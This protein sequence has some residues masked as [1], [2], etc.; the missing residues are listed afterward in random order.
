MRFKSNN[1]KKVGILL[2][3]VVFLIGVVF[4]ST[5]L[6]DTEAEFDSGNYNLTEF[7]STGGYI[8]LTG[9]DTFQQ[10]PNDAIDEN[11]YG[12]VNMTGN[13]GLWHM[14]EASGTVVDYSGAGN[15]GSP[16]GGPNYGVAGKLNNAISFEGSNEGIN[17]SND[18]SLNPS[19]MTL[20][21]WVNLDG[22]DSSYGTILSRW[23]N[24]NAYYIGTLPSS[25]AVVIYYSGSLRYTTP[26][27][28]TG[29]WVHFLVTNDGAG[30]T[31][32]YYQ[33]GAYVGGGASGGAIS[34][35]TSP[36]SIGYDVE[37]SN[38]PFK[39]NIDEFAIWNRSLSAQEVHDIYQRQKNEYVEVGEYTSQ[40]FNPGS[41]SQW[42]NLS[43]ID[44]RVGVLPA[45]Q[46]VE[47][48]ANM[49]FNTVLYYLNE[50][51]GNITDYSGNGYSAW[52]YDFEGDEYNATGQVGNGL[53]FDGIDDIL[54]GPGSNVVI[55]EN[56][57]YVSQ[58]VWFKTTS[59]AAMYPMSLK[60]SAAN[61]TLFSITIGNG[62]AGNAGLLTYNA[63]GGHTYLNHNGGY[64]DGNWHLLVGVVDGLDRIVYVDGVSVAS[65]TDGITSVTGNIAQFTV[66]G[67]AGNH[68]SLFFGGT[69]DD[70]AVFNRSLT[71]QEVLDIYNRGLMK[72]NVSV[73]SCDDAA[74]DGEGWTDINDTSP[75]QLSLGNNS[76]FQYQ[77]EFNGTE[78]ATPSLANVTIEYDLIPTLDHYYIETYENNQA[79]SFFA[80]TTEVELRTNTTGTATPTITITDSEGIIWV[81]AENMINVSNIY[82]YNYTLNGSQGWYDVKINSQD[83]YKTF[84]QSQT[85]QGNY[86]DEDGNPFSFRRKI[87][88]TEPGTRERFFEPI[89]TQI[90]F[91]YE[92][93]NNSVRV[94][95]YNG[96][97]YLEIPSQIYNTNQTGT[98]LYSS[99]VVFLSSLNQSETR[100]YYIVSSKTANNK[101]YTSDIIYSNTSDFY[102]ISNSYFTS[103][104]NTSTGGLMQNAYNA[105]GTN[106]S[107]YGAHPMD[108]YPEYQIG[109]TT[110]SSRADTSITIGN[111]EG[112]LLYFFNVS[113][114]SSDDSSKPYT[115]N[116]KI[117]SK[118]YQIICEK[119]QTSTATQDWKN[120]YMN[121]VIVE[122]ELFSLSAYENSSNVITNQSLATVSNLDQNMKWVAFY[123]NSL[124]NAI[125]EIFLN[126][127]FA[128]TNNPSFEIADD[129]GYDYYQQ[130]VID[131]TAQT[132]NSG[133]YFY[134]K[135]AK[136]IYNGMREYEFVDQ[137][138]D[139]LQNPVTID[140]ASEETSDSNNPYYI[141][142][143]TIATSDQANL[144]F[145]SYWA[146]DSF[147]DYAIINITG[148]G[149][150]GTSTVLYQNL[151]S[152]IRNG[153]SIVNES[154]VNITLNSSE[155]NAGNVTCNITAYDISGKYN[156][157]V[158]I[159]EVLDLTPPSIDLVLNNPNVTDDLDPNKTIEINVTLFEYSTLDKVNLYYRNNNSG[160]WS[161]WSNT[162][163]ANIVSST[164]NYTYA[165]NI[166]PSLEA[167]Y[168]YYIGA[169]DTDSNTANSS[170]YNLSAYF[171]YSWT[172][173]DN[174]TAN[175]GV[176]DTNISLGNLTL[177]NTGDYNLTFTGSAGVFGSRI[178]IN[179]SQASTSPQFEVENG[180]SVELNV[181][182]TTRES[183]QTEGTDAVTITFSNNTAT[184][185]S[186][187]ASVSLVTIS[188]GPFLHTEITQYNQTVN[189][190]DTGISLTARVTN[191]GNETATN[192]NVTFV[193]PTGWS[194][195][196]EQSLTSNFGTLSV[197]S[198]DAHQTEVDISSSA[199]AGAQTVTANSIC[200]ENKT[201]STY[202][203]ITVVDPNAGGTE[204]SE[205]T[206][207][208][209]GGGGGGGGGASLSVEE[210]NRF[211]SSEDSFELVRG[212]DQIFTIP[213]E[214]PYDDAIL[215][216]LRISLQGFSKDY[217]FFYPGSIS[218]LGIG[219]SEDIKVEITAPGYFTQG[220]YDLE[221][222]FEGKLYNTNTSKTIDFLYT[223]DVALY[224]FDV[225]RADATDYKLQA[226]TY[227]QD[228]MDRGYITDDMEE[229]FQQLDG[230]YNITEFGIVKDIFEQIEELYEAAVDSDE[231][232][233]ELEQALSEAGAKKINVEE[234]E[235]LVHLA[236]SSFERGD[237]L[238]ALERVKEAK[239]TLAIESSGKFFKEVTYAM[240]ENPGQT[241]AGFG[242]F[243]V[244]VV[245][246]SLFTRWRYIKRKLK[247]LGEE[248]NLLTELMKA[249]QIEV[250]EKAK[251]SMKEYGESM[252]QYEERLGNIIG[253]KITFQNKKDN[254]LKF[255]PK[256]KKFVEERDQLVKIMKET[257]EAYITKG[258]FE[259][260]IYENMLKSYSERLTD[261]EEKLAVMD[262]RKA[263]GNVKSK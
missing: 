184:P 117:Y 175:S 150:N 54:I 161:N 179:G 8:E 159:A 229:L 3:F 57:Q 115:Y 99:N 174:L 195:S 121:G 261:V 193:L 91:S 255:K 71:S 183:G 69:L 185:T 39:G 215:R 134:T 82:S 257:Q 228:M 4:A 156:S 239:L 20:S 132:V 258:K 61:S 76:Y 167:A 38:Y 108:Y 136:V 217:I 158:I 102:T 241:T 254:L 199:S 242:A 188:G 85:W 248:E 24:G 224:L 103:Y 208:S 187:T 213:L 72:L 216:N 51:S 88:V 238:I 112:Q 247:K 227:L 170:A 73:R 74:C 21:A 31:V 245:G 232:I 234:T 119:N 246:L 100:E 64:N 60:R 84:Y 5:Y 43:W 162:T 62:G 123:D 56:I 177:N 59:A 140:Q 138:Y 129:S 96:Y 196:A 189:L 122:D 86:T 192:T 204:S 22:G 35:S 29:E 30:N 125:G 18:V 49:T 143:G 144:T 225:S 10:F 160:S 106:L 9:N 36:S 190:G 252:I 110:Y 149:T 146:D 58:A 47:S 260:R 210:S 211:F 95:A 198:Y 166:T 93:A 218:Q 220:Q 202:V 155:I 23:N 33:N 113:G 203:T 19:E 209:S 65:D 44:G 250:F 197:G 263:K 142:N 12:G 251:M 13:V 28:P 237:F 32:S 14:N 46:Q 219:E 181:T 212:E 124:G 259:T 89:D 151:S 141:D 200:A 11:F 79:R 147:L 163:M 34:S 191:L 105:I 6:D 145:Y 17:L 153:T 126:S 235:R 214:N 40:I 7:N 130:R 172:I 148:P 98:T 41:E 256:R 42:L 243:G 114:Q 206:G 1:C 118:N 168:Q 48:D 221:F 244:S 262:V 231:G 50:I 55:G 53:T 111:I 27:L 154:S 15:N 173:T 186:D 135:T 78:N 178:F 101:A 131:S 68:G 66:G 233:Q 92:Q 128:T 94:L 182:G 194:V 97:N 205:E 109:L 139:N 77:F 90:N 207:G 81:N 249:V 157:T 164:Y 107:I 45:N 116:C 80:N 152:T 67:F 226:E 25:T 63:A 137:V 133:D 253:E 201:G 87:N 230:N 83:W 236:K 26:A 176:F 223:K 70:V 165:T 2:I 222:T 180:T 16:V 104:F 240:K 75:Q 171:D 52:A 37:R 120:F 169:N 127:T